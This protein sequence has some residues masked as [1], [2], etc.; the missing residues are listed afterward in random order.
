MCPLR[1]DAGWHAARPCP[2]NFGLPPQTLTR[3]LLIVNKVIVEPVQQDLNNCIVLCED[4]S[5]PLELAAMFLK[6]RGACA[7]LQIDRVDQ[8]NSAP[9]NVNNGKQRVHDSRMWEEISG[10][11]NVAIPL[12]LINQSTA[13]ELKQKRLSKISLC[14]EG[15]P[16]HARSEVLF[17]SKIDAAVKKAISAST[18]SAKNCWSMSELEL[19]PSSADE[20]GLEV[21]IN[22]CLILRMRKRC[23]I[24]SSGKWPMGEIVPLAADCLAL[25]KKTIWS[26]KR[27]QPAASST[28]KSFASVPLEIPSLARFP[29]SIHILLFL[30]YFRWFTYNCMECLPNFSSEFWGAQALPNFDFRQM[31]S[32]QFDLV[33]NVQEIAWECDSSGMPSIL[34]LHFH[35]IVREL[36]KFV[37]IR[38]QGS[39]NGFV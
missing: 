21:F 12:F 3:P 30:L 35:N 15:C 1:I 34:T 24:L 19:S 23:Q 17:L 27:E 37:K 14:V 31:A 4:L 16:S 29:F 28:A 18:G 39:K 10:L 2:A 11:T 9:I 33:S 36:H 8:E 5:V 20:A 13:R 26:L 38:F 22:F 25:A 6:H 32:V 7:M